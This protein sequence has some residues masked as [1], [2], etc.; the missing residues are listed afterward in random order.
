MTVATAVEPGIG[1]IVLD[2]PPLNI[3]TRDVLRAMRAE[4]ARLADQ[5]DL[6][7]LLLTAAGPHFSA[8][9]DI[10][11]HL[12]PHHLALIPDF[13][14]TVAALDAFPVPVVAAVRGRC[15]GGGFELVQ[16]ADL[17][18]AGEGASFGQPEIALGV[19]P[20]A[21]CVLLP[22]RLPPSL[23]AR[24]IYSGDPISAAEALRW[25]FVTRVVPDETVD[26]AA[27]EEA[28]RLARHSAP[29][30]RA[31]K[32]AVNGVAAAARRAALLQAGHVYLHELMETHDAVEG[33]RAFAE[34][35]RPV[36]RHA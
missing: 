18:V 6:R 20:P 27:L 31:A 15:L 21:A 14:D 10:G 12:P 17:I 33:L 13:L 9:A 3:L 1:R 28:R 32:Q 19:F 25:G 11:E 16:P 23:V 30:L 4:L 8:G 34:K 26:E 22:G 29:A 35:R 2:R 24:V 7:V 36:W 5:R